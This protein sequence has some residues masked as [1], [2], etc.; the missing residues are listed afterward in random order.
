[1]ARR[2]FFALRRRGKIRDQKFLQFRTRISY[3]SC[4]GTRQ[5]NGGVCIDCSDL[6]VAGALHGGHSS[7]VVEQG[8][9]LGLVAV[10]FNLSP[11]STFVATS[12]AREI[13]PDIRAFFPEPS[14]GV[15]RFRSPRAVLENS[16]NN[17]RHRL[18][19]RRRSF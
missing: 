9:P 4:S 2:L 19:C 10:F 14:R 13:R 5:G 8:A 3:R 6:G 17:P 16:A 11:P 18:W 7:E 12:L 15:Q 1:M